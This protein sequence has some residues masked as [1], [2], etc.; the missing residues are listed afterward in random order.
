MTFG[1]DKCTKGTLVR[2]RL[3]YTSSIVLGTD[4]KIKELYQEET[5]KYL[6]MGTGDGIQHVEMKEKI[7]QECYRRVRG[8]I[9]LELNAKNKLEV[10]NTL[11]IPVVTYSFYVVNWNLEEIKKRDKKNSKIDDL[12]HNASPQGRCKYNFCC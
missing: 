5:Y 3:K 10:I 4:T 6:G 7:R 2:G 11:A 8:V 1:L 9:Q 12:K